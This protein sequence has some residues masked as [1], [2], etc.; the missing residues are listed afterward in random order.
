MQVLIDADR[1]QRTI[2]WQEYV[3][4]VKRIAV[5]LRAMCVAMQDGVALLS[6]NDIYYYVLGDGA[7]AAGAA[8]AGIPTFVKQSEL[9]NCIVAAQVNGSSLHP[10]SWSW[11]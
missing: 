11:L 3:S 2:S 10:S 5:G 4:A 6:H 1:P 9:A 7:I 8:F